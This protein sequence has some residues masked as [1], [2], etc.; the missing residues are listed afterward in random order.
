[1]TF[2]FKQANINAMKQALLHTDW[3]SMIDNN[4]NVG[5]LN[6][7]FAESIV[8]AARAT[9]VP[10]FIQTDRQRNTSQ[11]EDNLY[12]ERTSL[13]DQLNS[14]T[15]LTHTNRNWNHDRIIEI[16]N[17]LKQIQQEEKLS[18]EKRLLRNITVNPKMFFK[19]ANS[20]RKTRT[21]IGPL[22][23]T[24]SFEDGPK[25][26]AEILCKQYQSVFST[27]VADPTITNF[28]LQ[29]V[30]TPI[31]DI[32][33]TNDDIIAAGKSIS[34]SSAPGPDGI[35]PII[36]HDYI[37]VLATPIHNIFRRS[38]DT[39]ILPEGKATAIITPIL[40]PKGVK[41]NPADYRPIALTNHLTKILE[42]LLRK[43]ITNH[44]ETN[45]L[46][47][48]TQHGFM[49]G[50]S[51]ITQ[52][53][54]FFDDILFM[55]DMGKEVDAVYLDFAKAF[56]KVDHGI[57]LHKIKQIRI[58]G[59]IAKWLEAFLKHRQQRVR[60]D[61]EL[62]DPVPVLSGVPQ[63]S[64]LGPLLFLI[65]LLDINK[66]VENT[67]VGSYADDTKLWK[68]IATPG[69][70]QHLQLQLET[71]YDW[72]SKNNMQLN[73]K[74]FESISIGQSD[75]NVSYITPSGEEIEI[76]HVVR[77]LGIEMQD[78]LTFN[79]HII[80]VATKGHKM[81]NWILRTFISRNLTTMKILLKS[82]VVPQTE[83]GS[84]IW[85]PFDQGQINLLEKIQK[86][87]TNKI[88]EFQINDEN[89][90][91]KKKCGVRYPERLKRLKIFSLER[92]RERYTILYMYKILIGYAP[93]VGLEHYPHRS[94]WVFRPKIIPTTSKTPNW[95]KKARNSSLFVKG[96]LLYNCLPPHLRGKTIIDTPTKSH[97]ENFK[98]RLDQ[99]LE[100]IPDIP[101]SQENTLLAAIPAYRRAN[102]N[103]HGIQSQ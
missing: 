98:Q 39:G 47:N 29:N 1:M 70:V 46:F 17:T 89:N 54:K 76:K 68:G 10:K 102:P 37:D 99:Y 100:K 2:N 92:R 65:L 85:G 34:L 63:G 84:V 11:R 94:Q 58:E 67:A 33:I 83:Y 82:I 45:N 59:K 28:P 4:P 79:A 51:T 21:R 69:D 38:L 41:C 42:R 49:H 91:G 23:S 81:E 72:C 40:K 35:P 97:V 53:L 87:F 8:M 25:Q 15:D 66:N 88:A 93:A 75:R 5:E 12:K 30:S 95:I 90:P 43:A 14:T 24:N 44:M 22:K 56:D 73:E 50:R 32:N 74:K 19:Y 18:M 61:G 80:T 13:T 101:G 3:N 9:R 57:L 55:L 6:D 64:V 78:N 36:Y 86:R 60:V 103:P 52:L 16:D 96:P 62:S 20:T 77:D 7:K 71:I 26:M 48:D 31:A 27:P